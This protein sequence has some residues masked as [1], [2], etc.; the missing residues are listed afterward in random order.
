MTLPTVRSAFLFVLVMAAAVVSHAQQ[1]DWDTT[2][3]LSGATVSVGIGPNVRYVITS[4]IQN[5]GATF[6]YPPI[7]GTN[8]QK[9]FAVTGGRLH[10][11]VRAYDATGQPVVPVHIVEC[12]NN[13][14]RFSIS[15]QGA[16]NPCANWN[17]ATVTV[18]LN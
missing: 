16:G 13:T 15:Q 6:G 2:V 5:G 10:I 8:I 14:R 12:P 7:D 3:S 1:A 4:Y 18:R 9:S 11:S 17:E